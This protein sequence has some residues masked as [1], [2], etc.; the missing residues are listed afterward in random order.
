LLNGQYY[1]NPTYY[2]LLGYE[3]NEVELDFEFWQKSIHPDD[4]NQAIE[5][6]TQV[7]TGKIKEYSLEYRMLTKQGEYK[8]FLSTTKALFSLENG[9]AKRI[10]GVIMDINERKL[11][12]QTIQQSEEKFKLLIEHNLAAICIYDNQHFLYANPEFLHLFGYMED[13]IQQ[14][15]P[16]AIIH[17]D[18][19]IEFDNP[20]NTP[21]SKVVNRYILKA[22][23]KAGEERWVDLNSTPI[24]YQNKRVNITTMYDITPRVKNE[25][26][27]KEAYEAIKTTEEELRQ[28][29]EEMSAINETLALTKAQLEKTL[30]HE[31][32]TNQKIERKNLALYNQKKELKETLRQ[33][34]QTQMQLVQAEKMA[35]LG[36]LVAGIAHEMNNPVNYINSSAEGLKSNLEDI[37]DLIKKYEEI[38]PDNVQKKLTEIANFREQIEYNELASEVKQLIE[39]I[40]EGSEQTAE[41]VRGLR[42]FSH[43][44]ATEKEPMDV[45]NSIET[46]LILLHNQY[47]YYIDIEKKLDQ[48]PI[49]FGQQSKLNQVILNLLT[50]A[51][52]AVKKNE[53]NKHGKIIIKTYQ[54]NEQDGKFVIIEIEDN[55]VGMTDSVK[56][57][58]FEPFFTTKEIGQGTGLGLSISLGIIQSFGGR[59]DVSSKPQIGTKIKIYLPLTD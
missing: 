41:I 59:I 29:T 7:I 33:L 57:R 31:K 55:G 23:T 30:D 37:I 54:T 58:I 3:L 25:I 26:A 48:V 14:L 22:I 43:L 51:I 56:K 6:E 47:K 32:K 19:S 12:E 16:E 50:N 49:L 34:K 10:M 21:S 36:V 40:S 5:L 53:E 46:G 52:Y 39:N 9:Q 8:W 24:M 42:T 15:N 18:L 44:E 45:R 35:S 17:P 4:C 1:H 13:E 20:S 11:A 38:N 27:L 28:N 2:R